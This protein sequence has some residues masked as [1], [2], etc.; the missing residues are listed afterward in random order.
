MAH[1]AVR[2]PGPRDGPFFTV[3]QPKNWH[4]TPR[5]RSR[6]RVGVG[7]RPRIHVPGTSG[8]V[9]THGGLRM[10]PSRDRPRV[11]PDP[12]FGSPDRVMGHFP[13]YASPKTGISGRPPG[14]VPDTVFTFRGHVMV[15]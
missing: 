11:G 9:F 6:G 4:F 10:C 13:P 2:V 14:S 3:R 1:H 15:F 5:G 8:A 12:G 7:D